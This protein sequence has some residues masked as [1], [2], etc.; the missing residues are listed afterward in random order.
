MQ[1]VNG[2]NKNCSDRTTS[3]YLTVNSCGF[4][5]ITDR[6][7]GAFRPLGR[8]DYQLIYIASGK[9]EYV[10]DGAR[11]TAFAGDLLV[12][13][14]REP[15]DYVFCSGMN[16]KVYWVHFTGTGAAEML[17]KSGFYG[18]TRY[19]I[20][21]CDEICADILELICEIQLAR[22]G[23]ELFC[24][25]VLMRT[26]ARASRLLDCSDSRKNI[27]KYD[28]LIPIIEKMNTDMCDT[29]SIED[30]AGQCFLDPY[31]F[32]SLFKEYT[33]HSPHTYRTMLKIEKAKQ[34]LS[35]TDMTV[36]E[37]AEF[38]GYRDAL[39][40][41]RVFRKYVGKAPGIYKKECGQR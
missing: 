26:V 31:Y 7:L 33:G 39:Y 36:G 30:Y 15:Q 37:I 13:R 10:S 17:S 32:I 8:S 35:G 21:V 23:Y 9:A 16:T 40:F 20:G 27:R 3:D 1:I 22:P 29:S 24:S 12:Y 11:N 5:E 19:S 14:P 6:D 4:Y 41:G 2:K 28:R 18:E 34:L 25:S 38:L